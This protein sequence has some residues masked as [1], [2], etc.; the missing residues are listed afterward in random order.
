M[1]VY[2]TFVSIL[3]VRETVIDFL[4]PVIHILEIQYRALKNLLKF[5]CRHHFS[6]LSYRS[7]RV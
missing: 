2:G 6:S 3:Y 4:G 5:G 7:V 1:E